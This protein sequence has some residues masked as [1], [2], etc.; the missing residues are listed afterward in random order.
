[1]AGRGGLAAPFHR[2]SADHIAGLVGV[3]VLDFAARRFNCRELHLGEGTHFKRPFGDPTDALSVCAKE[4]N[5]LNDQRRFWIR[6]ANDQSSFE[7]YFL[8]VSLTYLCIDG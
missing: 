6:I 4:F 2:R 8:P 1:M 7:R 5:R 3:Y